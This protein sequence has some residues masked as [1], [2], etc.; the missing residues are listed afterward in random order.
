MEEI[1]YIVFAFHIL[2]D[3]PDNLLSL[4]KLGCLNSTLGEK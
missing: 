3:Y 1:K 2:F 4:Q